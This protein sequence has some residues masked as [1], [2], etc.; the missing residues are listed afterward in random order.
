MTGAMSSAAISRTL[1]ILQ[2][3][4]RVGMEAEV[5]LEGTLRYPSLPFEEAED[6][7]ACHDL[8]LA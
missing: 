2:V 8:L 6:V 1:G 4:E 3:V 5:S 7:V